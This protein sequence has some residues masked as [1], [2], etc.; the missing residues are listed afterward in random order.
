M[1]RLK[2]LAVVAGLGLGVSGCINP[3]MQNHQH[4]RP[5]LSELGYLRDL[6]PLED[7]KIATL[8]SMFR[9]ESFAY[10]GRAYEIRGADFGGFCFI[11]IY[12]VMAGEKKAFDSSILDAANEL[13]PRFGERLL[14]AGEDQ[15]NDICGMNSYISIIGAPAYQQILTFQPA[16]FNKQ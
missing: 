16:G 3:G 15:I 11:K 14:R 7:P 2:E 10:N 8:K 6:R 4:Q 1:A 13:F 12:A 5:A 9:I